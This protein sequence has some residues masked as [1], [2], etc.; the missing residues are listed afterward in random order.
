MV[1]CCWHETWIYGPLACELYAF[2]GSLFGCVSIWSMTMI[3]FDRY[4]VIVKGLKAKPMTT[5]S[6]ML[7]ILAIWCYC[8][9]WAASPMLGWNK[10]VP[11]GN[12]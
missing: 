12:M 2:T 5:T 9:I 3:A 1:M 11:E 4:T 7:K 6:A 10:Y 8:A